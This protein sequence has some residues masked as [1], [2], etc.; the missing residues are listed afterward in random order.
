MSRFR[1][2]CHNAHDLHQ[3]VQLGQTSRGTPVLLNRLLLEADLI[4]CLGALEPHLLLGFGGGLK[5]II[6]G[7]AGA[8]T[9]GRNHLQGVDAEHFDYVGV[10]GQESPMRLDLEEGRCC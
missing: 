3:L 6:P 8:E 1:W 7:C 5:M 10:P 4:V 9:V 2:R